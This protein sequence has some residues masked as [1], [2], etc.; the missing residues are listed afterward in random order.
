MQEGREGYWTFD[1]TALRPDRSSC[2]REVGRSTAI[3]L[4]LTGNFE[5]EPTHLER[6]GNVVVADEMSLEFGADGCGW[7]I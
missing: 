3:G 6:R 2:R 1:S 4:L 7:S 5:V